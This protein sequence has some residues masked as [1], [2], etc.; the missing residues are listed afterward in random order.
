MPRGLWDL[1]SRP[2][3]EPGPGEVKTWSPNHWRVCY[4]TSVVSDS[5]RPHRRKPTRLPCPWDSPG[6]NTG[7]GC[8]ALLSG[9]FQNLSCIDSRILYHLGSPSSTLYID[10]KKNIHQKTPMTTSEEPRAKTG[11]W[12]QKQGTLYAPCT[13]HHQKGRQTT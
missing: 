1:S 11:C 12:E 3:I 5:V 7:V 13:Q 10:K 4:I 6:K 9:L 8:H 2:E